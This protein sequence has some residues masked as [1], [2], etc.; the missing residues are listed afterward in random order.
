MKVE[1][2]SGWARVWMTR[3]RGKKKGRANDQRTTEPT[4]V[5][6]RR[7]NETGEEKREGTERKRSREKE[8]TDIPYRCMM[9]HFHG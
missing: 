2:R 7:Y 9:K 5:R 4:R 8:I 1:E 6:T 3:R